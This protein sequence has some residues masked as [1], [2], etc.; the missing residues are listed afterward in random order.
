MIRTARWFIVGA[1]FAGLGACVLQS[2]PG[3]KGDDG[4]QGPPGE[5]GPPGPQGD[6]GPPGPAGEAGVPDST[7]LAALQAQVAAL[8]AQ[9]AALQAGNP[10]CPSGYTKAA[11]PPAAFLPAAVVCKKGVDEV[12]K[13]GT[14]ASAFWIDRYEATLWDN[15][16]GSG[17]QRFVGGADDS[18]AEF[19]KN[20]QVVVPLYALSVAGKEPARSMTWF[21]AAEA[22]AASGK[23]LPRGAEWLRAARGTADSGGIDG[24]AGAERRCNTLASGPRPTGGGVG[25]AQGA[26]CVSDWGAEDMIG[27][28]W[29]WTEE[30][31]A[32]L[33][34]ADGATWGK[35]T[36]P[37]DA[38]HPYAQD[39]TWNIQSSAL[40]ERIANV[41][42]PYL[43]AAS[44]R[45]G[46]YNV[47]GKSGVFALFLAGAP[48]YWN[49]NMG[50]RCLIAR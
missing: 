24:T 2:D 17:N 25:V 50:F 48:S 20:G 21:Q 45:G 27:N 11:A 38:A 4:A 32:G 44:A 1:L 13:V 47:G 16:D 34:G 49:E 33:G 9:V 6:A 42:V 37:D 30:W 41:P 40:G 31:H 39:A 8:E 7:A 23:R 5:A 46:P 3:P 22:C 36:W 28:V 35:Q 14:G 18:T 15:A 26:S 29:E 43:P 10:A 19:P 12:V